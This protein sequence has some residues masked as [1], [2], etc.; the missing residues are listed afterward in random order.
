MHHA[1]PFVIETAAGP[2]AGERAGAGEPALVLHGGPGLSDYAGPL[3]AELGTHFETIRYQQRGL[4]PS[5]TAPPF[6]VEA[7]VADAVAVLDTLGVRA[8]WLVGH[9]WGAHLA[10][11]IAVAHPDRVLGVVSID[12]LG[13]IPDGGVADLYAELARRYERRCGRPLPDDP[14]LE[15][16]WPDYFAQPEAAPPTPPLAFAPAVYE[17]TL[18]S[19]NEHF[20]QGTLERGLR[21]LDRPALFVHG[22]DDPLPWEATAATAALIPGAQI[23]VLDGC[24]HFP[25]LEHPGTIAAA[26]AA[27]Q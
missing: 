25:W 8:A 4:D 21:N 23:L 10:L 19:V 11:H 15:D 2:I 24:G 1:R 20:E 12:G 13:G 27:L 26:A 22:R 9:S 3:A 7:H 17:Q 14:Q 18:A 6:T 5:A 16:F